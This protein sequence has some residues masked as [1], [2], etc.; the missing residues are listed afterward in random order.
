MIIVLISIAILLAASALIFVIYMR[1]LEQ[2]DNDAFSDRRYRI[3]DE[4][5]RR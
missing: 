5:S 3:D 4:D 2:Q 1:H